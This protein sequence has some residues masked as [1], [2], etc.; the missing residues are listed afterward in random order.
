MLAHAVPSTNGSVTLLEE[1][2]ASAG[3]LIG[4]GTSTTLVAILGVPVGAPAGD[5]NH[6]LFGAGG[7]EAPQAAEG[8]VVV[9]VV[10]T[11]DD[12]AASV[13]LSVN[14]VGEQPA[15]VANGQF[16]VAGVRLHFGP[17]T[18]RVAAADQDNNSASK[19]ITVY[20]DVPSARKPVSLTRDVV[21]TIDDSL[22]T[23][24][25]SAND[26]PPITATRDQASGRF[27]AK[28]VPLTQGRNKLVSTAT[29]QDNNS[30]GKTVFVFVDT[31]PP[32]RPTVGV[33]PSV[34]TGTNITLT[35]TKAAGTSLWINGS[36]VASVSL[37]AT[38]WSATVPLVEG[39]NEFAVVA[40]DAA[41]NASAE[42]RVNVIVDTLPPVLTI[43]APAKTNLSPLTVTGTVD[44]SLT[45]VTVNGQPAA[46]T[47]RAFSASVNL[48]EG[49]NSVT[50]IATSPKGY[51]TTKTVPVIRGTI[52]TIQSVQ[53]LD[54]KKFYA[55]SPT[56]IQAI[57]TDKENDPVTFQVL[58]DGA[59][60][61]DW[62]AN[63]SQ[64]WTPTLADR[65]RRTVEIRVQDGFGGYT[66]KQVSVY[67][68][69]MPVRP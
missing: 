20:V 2:T 69:R 7:Q 39:D 8:S 33:T 13:T 64:T 5:A 51:A 10:S 57:A 16:T 66:S 38:T 49:P 46:R 15:V 44:D 68:I 18:L 43:N 27:I 30:A 31:S 26:G 21:L 54:G 1:T 56:T 17:N 29:D 61:V 34:T 45:T 47:R 9:D 32:P 3:G 12:P 52:P 62:T 67:V 19:T 55:G 6:Q 48:V 37:E 53:P 63:A 14:G 25:V 59:I 23:A 60:L 22:A 11:I 28:A 40:K 36:R 41:G 65:G 42:N 50:V 58:L 24:T 35:G 4:A